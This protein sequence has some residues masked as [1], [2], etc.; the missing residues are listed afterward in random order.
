MYE[1]AGKIAQ[2]FVVAIALA[3]RHN[4]F[5]VLTSPFVRRAL[6]LFS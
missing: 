5:T 1:A 6:G 2:P 4:R 3:A